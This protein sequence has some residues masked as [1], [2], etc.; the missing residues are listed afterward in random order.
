VTGQ[1][2]VAVVNL[3]TNA[4]QIFFFTDADLDS[5]NII[6]TAPMAALGLNAASMFDFSVY[7][8]DNYFTGDLTD[9]VEDI[10]FTPAT[11]RFVASGV[12]ATGVPAGGSSILTIQA[13]PGGDAASPSQTGILL[14]Y[15]DG[16][17]EHEASAIDVKP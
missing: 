11:P 14:M 9:A 10:T 13:V 7:A 17:I 3:S 16:K 5:G 12:P 6:L 4:G 15:R 1:N 2:V 8:F